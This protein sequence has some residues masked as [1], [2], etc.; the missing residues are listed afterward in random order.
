MEAK[1]RGISDNKILKFEILQTNISFL[2]YFLN[3]AIPNIYILIQTRKLFFHC[4]NTT[5][6]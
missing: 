3:L 6:R 5:L 1:P 2:N 4:C